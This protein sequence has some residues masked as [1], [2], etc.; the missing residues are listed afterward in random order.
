MKKVISKDGTAIAYDKAGNGPLVVLV[1]GALCSRDFGPM[2]KLAKLLSEN[3]T[4]INYDRR[5][6]NDSNDNKPYAVEREI[7]DLE[8]LI[9]ENGGSANVFGISSGAGLA[10]LSVAH[11]LHISK[12]ALYEPPFMVD[13]EGHHPPADSLQQ[14]QAMVADDRRADAVKYFLKDM[15]G[16]PGIA[17]FMM[18][19]MP[20]WSKLKGVAHT[21]P[22]DVAVM[23][24][25]SLPEK[26]AAS[27]TAPTLI[28]G[29]DKSQITLQHAVKRLSEVMPNSELKI[30]KG[31]THN[32]SAKVIAPV[33]I[34]FF[35]K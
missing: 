19:L 28:S 5:G 3:F 11:G 27:V 35:K 31:Q 25:Y 29:G 33:L 30:L 6:R 1:D 22:Y 32:V 17:I 13:A 18:K 16:L 10:L 34:D 15:I 24:D 9:N 26:K 21:L 7:E 23:G 20:I 14:L 2:P 4:V 8:A 12:L